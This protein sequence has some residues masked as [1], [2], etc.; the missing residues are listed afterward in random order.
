MRGIGWVLR[1]GA[2]GC[3]SVVGG[4][5][6][7][8]VILVALIAL[9]AND[10]DDLKDTRVP[11]AE[12]SEG[13]VETAG[14]RRVKVTLGAIQDPVASTNPFQKPRAGY[15]YLT[16]SATIEN[17]GEREVHGGRVILRMVDA[18]EYDPA[19]I[20]GVG[21]FG[22]A[23]Q[24]L[25]SGGRTDVTLA[26]EVKDGSVIDWLKFDPNLAAKGDLYF[27]N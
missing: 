4:G 16:I 5:L 27:D 20:T 19:L 17:I 24:T 7:L 12:G 25:T 26:F 14:E 6:V 18:T 10:N 2:V 15:H 11:L 13:I 21:A 23:F 1:W 3:L 9:A 8:L 22:N